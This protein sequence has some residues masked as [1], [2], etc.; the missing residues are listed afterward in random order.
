MKIAIL[1]FLAL[2]VAVLWLVIRTGQT[3]MD[4]EDMT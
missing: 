3:L 4:N 2:V 1:L